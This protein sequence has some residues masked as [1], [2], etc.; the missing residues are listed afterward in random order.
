MRIG[1]LDFFLNIVVLRTD[2]SAALLLWEIDYIPHEDIA[3]HVNW[4]LVANLCVVFSGQGVPIL[5]FRSLND[6]PSPHSKS[7][8][9]T[10]HVDMLSLINLRDY[11]T[12]RIPE[13]G[14]I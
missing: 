11:I 12:S 2:D 6:N 4:V 3:I 9:T 13:S 7:S 8:P 10:S 1:S 14:L 5:H